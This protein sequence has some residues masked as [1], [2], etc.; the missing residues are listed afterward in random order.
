M[1][2]CLTATPGSMLLV[3][4]VFFVLL[5]GLFVGCLG[6]RLLGRGFSLCLG[7]FLGLG[8]H[9]GIGGA[10]IGVYCDLAEHLAGLDHNRILPLAVLLFQHGP[11]GD[12]TR[13]LLLGDT[14]RLFRREFYLHF[15]RRCLN[16]RR[17]AKC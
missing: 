4:L 7:G 5:I 12:L 9:L 17:R 13:V 6:A 3:L 16:Q 11:L 14:R 2:T 1:H 15:G 8:R 10:G